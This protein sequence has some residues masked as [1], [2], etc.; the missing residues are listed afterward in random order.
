MCAWLV[1]GN[2]PTLASSLALTAV[3]LGAA[4]AQPACGRS[5]L[6]IVCF[7]Y[8]YSV[9]PTSGLT[10]LPAI[11]N[12][13]DLS[14]QQFTFTPPS[15]LVNQETHQAIIN[16][17][18][19]EVEGRLRDLLSD[20]TRELCRRKLE[21]QV[22]LFD[23]RTDSHNCD[24]MPYSSEG[25][26]LDDVMVEAS[27]YD[28]QGFPVQLNPVCFAAC[29]L[30]DC[31]SSG[32]GGDN[33]PLPGFPF[34][35]TVRCKCQVEQMDD[36]SP[37]SPGLFPPQMSSSITDDFCVPDDEP[38]P[39]EYCRVSIADY[40]NAS[41]RAINHYGGIHLDPYDGECGN[42]DPALYDVVVECLA[43]DAYGDILEYA[44]E[45]YT[46][47][48]DACEPGCSSLACDELQNDNP[49]DE[50]CSIDGPMGC[51]P[52][53][54]SVDEA[55]DCDLLPEDCFENQV[56]QGV[57]LPEPLGGA[58]DGSDDGGGS[59]RL[60]S[61][62]NLL[63]GQW[64]LVST[65]LTC[66]EIEPGGSFIANTGNPP[67]S[68]AVSPY[69][70]TNGT[71]FTTGL[72]LT[73]PA[74]TTDDAGVSTFDTTLEELCRLIPLCEASRELELT[75]T[76]SEDETP[77]ASGTLVKSGATITTT[78]AGAPLSVGEHTVELCVE[79]DATEVEACSAQSIRAAAPLGSGVDGFGYFAGE[80]AAD[81]VPLAGKPEARQLSL[82]DN[83]YG[84]F[85]LPSGFEFP[86]Y[87]TTVSTYLYVGANGGINTTNLP[88]A[89]GNTG[90]PASTSVSAPDIAVYWDD[91]D[92]SS[93]GG[94]YGW[95]D[96]TRF[97]VSWEDVPHG[98]DGSSST[99][100]GV[101]V[102]AHIYASGRIELHHL[103]TD[104]DD[105]AH[106]LG[107]SATIGIGN[108]AGTQAVEVTYDSNALLTSGVVAVGLAL[109]SNGCLADGLVIPP[110]VACAANDH[111][112]TV[113]IPTDDTITLPLPDVSE[114][115][116]G[117]VG[118]KGVVI[119]SGTTESTLTPLS[120]PIPID[121]YGNVELDEGVHRIRWWPIDGEDEHVGPAFTQIVLLGTWVHED[122]G[123][124]R[125]LMLLTDGDDTYE[126]T[127][128]DALALIGRPG[129][130]VLISAAGD[131]FIGDGPDAGICEANE[132]ADLLVGEDGDDTLDAGP[133][134]DRAW[135]GTGDDLLLGGTGADELHGRGGHDIIE[136]DAHDDAL[137]G[138]LGD[139][140]LEGGEG[141][142]TLVP[143]AGVD[144]VY[145][146]PGDD[147]ILILDVCELTSGKL[148]SGGTGTDTL[149]LAPGL[150]LVVVGAAGVTVDA[151]I[152]LVETSVELPTHLA[153]C[154][155]S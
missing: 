84:R 105:A 27:E 54:C 81:F 70:L 132:G 109:D 100:D 11:F 126:A 48:N 87:G 151:D 155:P 76:A 139:D 46:E 32:T 12:P 102:Q 144:A 10:T 128:P 118:V 104:V 130:D 52:T 138:G 75:I 59:G 143:G 20:A 3:I 141:A 82:S 79:H 94:V 6:E 42:F 7:A 154:E 103:D 44:T 71:S 125:S 98:R 68:S 5:D 119:Q 106:D 73:C 25:I 111:Y 9:K 13:G 74:P 55:C 31:H 96:G 85:A 110:Q 133:G 21:Q 97:I 40:F 67:T 134:D 114:C 140:E 47:Q 147:V 61:A 152:E 99:T 56:V 135:G 92:P 26:G 113:C 95:F 45:A 2:S 90:L 50:P 91:L 78:Q 127:E 22:M 101:S 38:S 43:V 15:I 150:D 41:L 83:G 146:G 121:E 66:S 8:K 142:D 137:W 30:D 39:A 37:S 122:C 36:C 77:L 24:G 28:D 145:G 58:D 33:D 136:G 14:E 23:F 34:S 89:A 107:K 69:A 62:I 19:G 148:L 120:V 1:Q 65:E 18:G 17:P 108:L 86:F 93:G 123:G 60:R 131:D 35:R 51:T 149:L 117:A 4:A 116:I 80:L 29:L 16:D 64:L 72:H 124:G 49:L 129:A 53:N 57:C 153:T 112:A 115:T 88:I 63:T